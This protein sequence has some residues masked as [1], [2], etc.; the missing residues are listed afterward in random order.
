M[1]RIYVEW[2]R[3]RTDRQ[4][5][6]LARRLTQ[7]MSEVAGVAPESVSVVFNEI[8]PARQAK[9]GVFWS[10][11][12]KKAGKPAAKPNRAVPAKK[13]AARKPRAPRG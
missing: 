6:E 1:P 13:T 11:V 3:T 7:A 12:L 5:R 9:G 4:R 2:L 10:D 8:D